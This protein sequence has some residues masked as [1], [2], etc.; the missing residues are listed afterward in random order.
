METDFNSDLIQTITN[1]RRKP[2]AR[3]PCAAPSCGAGRC[4]CSFA[5]GRVRAGSPSQRPPGRAPGQE[6]EDTLAAAGSEVQ[7]I[8]AAL[9]T[10]PPRPWLRSSSSS[11][12][13]PFKQQW[14]Q[15]FMVTRPGRGGRRGGWGLETRLEAAQGTRTSHPSKLVCLIPA[16]GVGMRGSCCTWRQQEGVIRPLSPS[17][18]CLSSSLSPETDHYHFSPSERRL[19][20]WGL[21]V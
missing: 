19:S 11:P 6:E 10:G 3:N 15:G 20:S 8:Q 5:Q 13:S 4:P 1:R 16:P 2:Q 7:V 12:L 9:R 17:G 21:E 18:T 14:P